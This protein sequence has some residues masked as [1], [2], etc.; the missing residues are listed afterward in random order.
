MHIHIKTMHIFSLYAMNWLHIKQLVLFMISGRYFISTSIN[1][2][3]CASYVLS[4]K[5]ASG[6]Y[7]IAK[8]FGVKTWASTFHCV[9]IWHTYQGSS[10]FGVNYSQSKCERLSGAG[11]HWHSSEP[12]AYRERQY[13]DLNCTRISSTGE[14]HS[15]ISLGVTWCF[16]VN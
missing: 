15:S 11:S 4:L 6:K 1:I 13:L 12:A 5:P 16:T 8:T 14:S 7:R 10:A 3:M 9:S 2:A